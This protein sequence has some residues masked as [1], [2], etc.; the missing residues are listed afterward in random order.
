MRWIFLGFFAWNYGNVKTENWV[1]HFL[2]KLLFRGFSS[3]KPAKSMST[4]NYFHQLS[5]C[6]CCCCCLFFILFFEKNLILGFWLKP[7][8]L[9][10]G[11][12]YIFFFFQIRWAVYYNNLF[13]NK[14]WLWNKIFKVVLQ[15]ISCS[16]EIGYS[17]VDWMTSPLAI[18]IVGL[19]LCCTCFTHRKLFRGC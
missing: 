6:C 4:W 1:K 15:L 11:W 7:S 18:S 9:V 14:N 19:M 5:F 16:K 8:W 2:K 3:E 17:I 13:N 10:V 12:N